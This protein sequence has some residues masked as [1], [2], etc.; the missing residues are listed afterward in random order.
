[1]HIAIAGNIGSGKTTLTKLLSGEFKWTPFYETVEINP[2]LADFYADMKR[3]SFS[4]QVFFLNRRFS[5]LLTIQSSGQ[6]VVQD[7]TIF[8]DSCI[9]APNLHEM[10][11]MDSRDF[12]NYEALFGL[13]MS[14]VR[15]PDLVIYL[16]SSVPNLVG[17]IQKRG[18]EYENSIRLDYL[19]SLNRRYDEWYEEYD[20]NKMT[21]DVDKCH[22]ESS[23]TDLEEVT[24]LVRSR[25][26]SAGMR[27]SSL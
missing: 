26:A 10:G 13:M 15:K 2:Y 4:V 19:N 11:L 3:W 6:N 24:A 20:G 23:R 7:R 9:F 18:R 14:L 27:S 16:K 8:E 12:D 25:L 5:D 1:M 21:I 22:F 17:Q